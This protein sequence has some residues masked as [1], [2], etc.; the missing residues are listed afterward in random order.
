MDKLKSAI[1][2]MLAVKHWKYNHD[3]NQTLMNFSMR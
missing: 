3:Y 1:E 2:K